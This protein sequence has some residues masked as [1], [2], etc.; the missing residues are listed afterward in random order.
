V[1]I[2]FVCSGNICRSPTAEVVMA[3]LAEAA[4]IVVELDSAGTGDWHVGDDMDG[5]SRSTLIGA[6]YRP[7]A[8]RAKQ[9]TAADFATRDLV[10]ALDRGHYAELG[11]L[12]GQARDPNE[13]KA[14]IVLLRQFDPAARASGD[15]DV[16]DPYYGGTDGFTEVLGDIERACAG[17]LTALATDS[18]GENYGIGP[19]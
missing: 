11:E 18:V 19:I 4:G 1:R 5:R 6:G 14:K 17:L 3:Q 13:A 9:F 16:G 12:A 15:L 8:H 7:P 10:V 2:C